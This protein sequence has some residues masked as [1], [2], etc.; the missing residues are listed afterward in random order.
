MASERKWVSCKKI[1]WALYVESEERTW[2]HF[3]GTLRPF[4][5]RDMHFNVRG[6]L[7]GGLVCIVTPE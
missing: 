3:S 7:V 4:T 1:K 5:L 2:D 6:K